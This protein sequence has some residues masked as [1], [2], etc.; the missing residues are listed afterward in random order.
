VFDGSTTTEASHFYLILG[1]VGLSVYFGLGCA[2]KVASELTMLIFG[3]MLIGAGLITLCVVEREALNKVQVRLSP[4]LSLLSLLDELLADTPTSVHQFVGGCALV[5]SF[6]SPI[7]Q[8]VILSS[9]ST[10]LGSQPQGTHS[11]PLW[12]R[13]LL[14]VITLTLLLLV[15][16][17]TLMGVITMAGSVGRIVFPLSISVLDEQGSFVVGAVLSAVCI[18]GIVCYSSWVKCVSRP[19]AAHRFVVGFPEPIHS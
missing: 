1:V 5:L 8:T 10:V 4:L 12:P 7:V 3:F 18:G 2:R 17:G 9:F 19:S 14:C 6:G 11:R 15:L 16:V 13:D